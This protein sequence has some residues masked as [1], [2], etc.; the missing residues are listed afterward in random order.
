MNAKYKVYFAIYLQ[1]LIKDNKIYLLTIKCLHS[2]YL[3]FSF[4]TIVMYLHLQAL[5]VKIKKISLHVIVHITHD[6]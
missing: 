4:K 1:N 6:L 5:H 3:I 2:D